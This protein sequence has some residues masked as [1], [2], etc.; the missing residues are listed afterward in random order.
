MKDERDE[1]GD[2]LTHLEPAG[3]G[4]KDIAE[5]RFRVHIALFLFLPL[6]SECSEGFK[7][8]HNKRFKWSE[9]VSNSH[10]WLKVHFPLLLLCVKP[11]FCSIWKWTRNQ[12]ISKNIHLCPRGCCQINAEPFLWIHLLWISLVGSKKLICWPKTAV[13]KACE[14][15]KLEECG[16][17][18]WGDKG[19]W[20]T[21]SYLGRHTDNTSPSAKASRQGYPTSPASLFKF[22]A[23][24]CV[25]IWLD[26]LLAE[27]IKHRK[28]GQF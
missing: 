2:R 8:C 23:Y 3:E 14:W 25:C 5:T 24:V 10:V 18:E 7:H 26:N 22:S 1:D 9:K 12:N 13:G 20:L 4:S 28:E 27:P 21:A 15:K 16:R 19:N 11:V 17:S 6:R